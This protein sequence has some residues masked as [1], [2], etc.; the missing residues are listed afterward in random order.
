MISLGVGITKRNNHVRQLLWRSVR[1]MRVK[2][3]TAV[4]HVR[5]FK[6]LT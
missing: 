6:I 4:T 1:A 2:H 3:S 5:F